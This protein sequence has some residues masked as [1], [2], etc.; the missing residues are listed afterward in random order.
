MT[1][2]TQ[3]LDVRARRPVAAAAGGFTLL[4][5]LV[6]LTL[7]GLIL[8]LIFG[9]LQ[10]GTRAW[11][12]TEVNIEDQAEVRLV[13]AFLRRYMADARPVLESTQ[14]A[15]RDVVFTGSRDALSFV[16]LMPQ[17][18][19]PP[20][21]YKLQLEFVRDNDG[22][23]LVFTRSLYGEESTDVSLNEEEDEQVL[24][25]GIAKVE[26]S[27]FGTSLPA[28]PPQWI[29]R[30]EKARNL[31]S[32]VGLRIEFAEDDGRY[33]PEMVVKTEIDARIPV[34]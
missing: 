23:R 32:L 16:A 28:Q 31:P 8:A 10:F 25:N 4:E 24:L 9:G 22:G 20:G 14:V 33:W 7:L 17:H 12:T 1:Y 30:W 3:A 19:G 6:A 5:L 18:L 21:L 34:R 2:S 29:D 13:Q 26:F 15:R 11:E 27:Y